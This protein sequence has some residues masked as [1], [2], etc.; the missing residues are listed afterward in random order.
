VTVTET[1]PWRNWCP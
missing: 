1:H